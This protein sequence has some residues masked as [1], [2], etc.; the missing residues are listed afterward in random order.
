MRRNHP[1]VQA[2]DF[3]V[4]GVVI[5]SASFSPGENRAISG[6]AICGSMGTAMAK[7]R[8]QPL[9]PVRRATGI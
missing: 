4:S 7:A 3:P 2:K 8:N 6:A 9:D 1:N 5:N